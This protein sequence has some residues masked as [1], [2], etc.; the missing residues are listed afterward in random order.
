MK[1]NNKKDYTQ[2]R[3]K[4]IIM[5]NVLLIMCTWCYADVHLEDNQLSE[6]TSDTTKLDVQSIQRVQNSIQQPIEQQ[7]KE[8]QELSQQNSHGIQQQSIDET[9]LSDYQMQKKKVAEQIRLNEKKGETQT[10]IH[11]F[12]TV[13][14]SDNLRMNYYD[15]IT[16]EMKR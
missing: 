15:G 10:T 16:V 5:M 8:S 2:Q 13:N 1:M 7:N 11:L 6:Q 4:K 9:V 14:E 3:V 12:D